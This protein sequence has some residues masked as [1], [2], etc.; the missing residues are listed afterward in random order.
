MCENFVQ[1]RPGREDCPGDIPCGRCR[2]LCEDLSIT[3][4]R[5]EDIPGIH[6][7]EQEVEGGHGADQETLRAR[8]RMFPE[9]F[10]VARCR[11]RIAGYLESMIWQGRPFSRF[12]EIQDFPRLHNPAGDELYLIFLAVDPE[13]RSRGVAGRLLFC[14]SDVGRK[15]SL[16]RIR[17]VAKEELILFYKANGFEIVRPLP[18]FHPCESFRPY[19]MQKHLPE[20]SGAV[21]D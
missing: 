5:P 15:F 18:D 3:T 20:N 12:R 6:A 19:L 1:E 21:S 13:F 4:A 10:L 8:L 2:G 9:G 11:D 14:L 7:L 17:L 16:K